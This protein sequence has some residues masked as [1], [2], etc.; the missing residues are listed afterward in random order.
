VAPGTDHPALGT[1]A[2]RLHRRIERVAAARRDQHVGAGGREAAG[3]S[4]AKAFAAAGDDGSTVGEI[5]LHASPQRTRD[6]SAY[7]IRARTAV[8]ARCRPC[9]RKL[10]WNAK[11]DRQGFALPIKM[12][13]AMSVFAELLCSGR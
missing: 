12:T 3:D 10:G 6:K 2:D 11:S 1:G 8:A 7:H 4:V 13:T 9:R 5:D